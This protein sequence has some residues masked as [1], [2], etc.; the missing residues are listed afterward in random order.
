VV[1][2]E[3]DSIVE[4]N[5]TFCRMVNRTVNQLT[6]SQF[7]NMIAPSVVK[8]FERVF[9]ALFRE[10]EPLSLETTLLVEGTTD[11]VEVRLEG[12]VIKEGDQKLPDGIHRQFLLAIS[13]ISES[14]SLQ[15]QLWEAQKLETVGRLA[16]GVA[17]DF[18]NTLM[19]IQGTV[20]VARSEWSGGPE[21]LE[22]LNQI[23][24]ASQRAA[25][26]VK[27]L[28]SFAHK[29]VAVPRV[30]RIDSF[31]A[32]AE[33]MLKRLLPECIE[34]EIT[35]EEDLHDLHI[36]PV[37]LDQ[38]LTNLLL[39]ARDAIENQGKIT[40]HCRNTVLDSLAC[41]PNP[42]SLPGPYLELA[43]HDTGKG[44]SAEVQERVFE[45]FFTT[46]PLGK[47]TG[48]GLSSV[49][50][51]VVQNSGLIQVESEPDQGTTFTIRLPRSQIRPAKPLAEDEPVEYLG[52][53]DRV[54]VVEDDELILN[55]IRRILARKGYQIKAF[56][57]PQQALEWFQS[58][59][60]EVDLV[61]S[62]VI[63][64]AMCGPDMVTAMR[65]KRADLPCVFISGYSE[66]ELPRCEELGRV[67]EIL[68]PKPFDSVTLLMAVRNALR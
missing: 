13:N 12:G 14:K 25:E 31:M 28:L 66:E 6:G 11:T 32:K 22:F 54:L 46:K 63:M 43:M 34:L 29:G 2:D 15:H 59:M 33:P 5:D 19:I 9:P 49:Y 65:E 47:G 41:L 52:G 67:D 44:M 57:A 61:I 3:R 20:D 42:G 16:G 7:R 23:E 18:N 53:K 48:L 26:L 37:Q 68:V 62:D 21:E 1:I 55:L 64:P 38:V 27:H 40:I 39:N 56:S 36:D 4:A 17:H 24:R 30:L 8:S 58:N 60:S 45:P 35:M 51:I 50:G 10:E